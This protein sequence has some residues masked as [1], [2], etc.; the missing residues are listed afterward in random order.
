M[1]STLPTAQ[2][3]I[4]PEHAAHEQLEATLRTHFCTH[5]VE[6]H[7]CFC[8]NCRHIQQRMHSAIVWLAPESSYTVQDIEVIFEKT[9]F[10]LQNN[11]HF[12]FVIER[13][14]TLTAAVANRLLKILEEPPAGY[15]FIL[16]AQ[17]R[18]TVLPTI[19]SRCHIALCASADAQDSHHRLI[20]FFLEQK[21]D[22]L[23]FEEVLA[24]QPLS[25]ALSIDIAQQL[26]AL[27][28]EKLLILLKDG[29]EHTPEY[30]QLAHMHYVLMQALEY[31]PQAG[32][33]QLFW[34]NLFLAI[35]V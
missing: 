8:T 14:E 27:V 10:A 35:T 22:P 25:E 7:S 13:S 23:E 21:T 32:S 2:L 26:H 33:S 12:F 28:T 18:A 20:T 5:F 11:E 19:A 24:S 3:I 29:M 1:T 34:R 17:N 30:A 4:G 9:R 16:L 6:D 15:H 31:P